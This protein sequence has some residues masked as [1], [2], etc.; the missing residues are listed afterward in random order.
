MKSRRAVEQHGVLLNNHFKRVPNFGGGT[1]YHFSCRL[2][3]CNSLCFNKAF[4]NKGLEKLQRHFFRNAALVHFKLRTYNY[5]RTSRIVNTFTEQVLT[6]TSLFTF[7][8]IR[9]GFKR[10]VVGACY[11][12]AASAVINKCVHCLLQHTLFI[13]DYYIRR[14]QLKQSL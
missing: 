13:A 12:L 6:E 9:K 14:A 4:H 5:N 7:Q 1:L 8:H 2:N 10:A 11:R 3:I